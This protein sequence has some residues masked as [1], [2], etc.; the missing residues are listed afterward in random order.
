[1]ILIFVAA[2]LRSQLY[3][4]DRILIYD[5]NLNCMYKKGKIR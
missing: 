3:K 1:M 2:Y 5:N 4:Y